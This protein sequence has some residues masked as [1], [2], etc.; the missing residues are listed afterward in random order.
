[1]PAVL[2][3]LVLDASNPRS[4]AYQLN[5][6]ETDLA[7]SRRTSPPARPLRLLDRLVERSG[8]PTRSPSAWSW[9]PADRRRAGRRRRARALEAF[10]AELHDALR[11][12]VRRPCATTT[13]SR[14]PR[15]SPCRAS[16]RS[17]PARR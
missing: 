2:D 12:L 9:A 7:R 14:R 8:W 17:E 16:R 3:L 1:M 11:D 6:Y 13:T 10:C 5:R 15:S 4:V